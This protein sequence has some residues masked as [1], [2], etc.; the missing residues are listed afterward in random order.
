MDILLKP[1]VEA[2]EQMA[3]N[4]NPRIKESA[5]SGVQSLL[6][7]GC[8]RGLNY[9][10]KYFFFPRFNF[11]LRLKTQVEGTYKCRVFFWRIFSISRECH[12]MYF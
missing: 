4:C 12:K 5:K 6:T 11:I 10:M 1:W 9:C 7:C 8:I 2:T 3:Q